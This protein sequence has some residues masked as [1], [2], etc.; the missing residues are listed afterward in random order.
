M[1]DFRFQGS[2]Q[3]DVNEGLEF[4][5]RKRYGGMRDLVD[6]QNRVAPFVL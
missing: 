4:Q 3:G 5:N 2:K 6:M 1:R